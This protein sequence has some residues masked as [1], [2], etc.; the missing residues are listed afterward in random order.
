MKLA[1][2]A[3]WLTG[4]L[5]LMLALWTAASLYFVWDVEEAKYRLIEAKDGYEIRR[6]A[7]MLIAETAYDPKSDTGTEDAFRTLAA[8]IFGKNKQQQDIGMTAPVIMDRDKPGEAISM[9]APVLVRKDGA[10]TRMAFVMPERFTLENLPRPE[11]DKITIREVPARLVAA[12]QFSWYAPRSRRER[13]ADALLAMLKRDRL[14][15]AG[16]PVYAGYNPPFSVPFIKRHEILV[17]LADG[18]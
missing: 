10:Q 2:L 6:Y 11:D 13:K 8:Y 12:T 3:I 15:P 18:P 5:A 17:E 14:T 16:D 7:P 4:G 1:T 9:T